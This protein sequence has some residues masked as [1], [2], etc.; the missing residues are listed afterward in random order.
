MDIQTV[1]AWGEFLG[2][3]GGLVAAIGVIATLVYLAAQIRH[4]TR[5]VQ[6]SS[7]QAAI[8]SYLDFNFLVAGN[9]E[10]ADLA[11]KGASDPSSL[12]ANQ[13]SRFCVAFSGLLHRFE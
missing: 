8:S 12:D 11:F 13:W 10:F 5:A 4:N 6:S 9:S 3:I 1:G 2:G 7:W